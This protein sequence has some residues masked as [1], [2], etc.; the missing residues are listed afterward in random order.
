ME[1]TLLIMAAGMGSRYGGL[2]QVEGFGPNGETLLEYGIADAG[3]AGFTHFVF[4]IRK[5]IEEAFRSTVLSR[6]G[7]NLNYD[8]VFQELD[9]LPLDVGA[10]ERVKPWG[11]GHAV[12]CAR[13][14]IH[15][16]FA[17]MNADDYYGP[18][19]FVQLAAHLDSCP[20]TIPEYA[21]MGYRL[22]QTLSPSGTV[23]RGICRVGDDGLLQSVEEFSGLME[24]EG[25]VEGD[26][27]S[28]QLL[29]LDAATPV[30]MNLWGLTPQVFD[31]LERGLI[32]FLADP[33]N[34]ARGEY[35][36]PAA[37]DRGVSEG[38]CRVRVLLTG[39]K[40]YGVTYPDDR[41]SVRAAL[42]G[43]SI[44]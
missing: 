32:D 3:K 41:E 14:V 1:K 33:E 11:T 34:L 5:D 9:R 37:I 42:R 19:A 20:S 30:S 28:G 38:D 25:R 16:P 4:V 35:Y 22:D 39:D 43:L 31:L 29:Q 18:Q 36:L 8:L 10:V 23:S 13:A 21:M 26:S 15:T 12:W 7:D 2:K 27:S 44:L 17:V 40:W 24:K 6:F